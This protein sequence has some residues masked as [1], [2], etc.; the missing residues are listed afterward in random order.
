[1][2]VWLLA[3]KCKDFLSSSVCKD[4]EPGEGAVANCISEGIAAAE[5]GEESAGARCC[6]AVSAGMAAE[7]S[8]G[9]EAVLLPSRNSHSVAG[10]T[11]NGSRD[12]RRWRIGLRALWSD[13]HCVPSCCRDCA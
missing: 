1:M 4:L 7:Q 11:I 13:H 8:A 6:S 10:A 3:G 9:Q 5:V 12:K 2:F